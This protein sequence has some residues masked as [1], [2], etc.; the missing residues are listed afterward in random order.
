MYGRGGC[1]EGDGGKV[2]GSTSF[3]ES[4]LVH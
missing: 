1:G 2:G 3:D 4:S